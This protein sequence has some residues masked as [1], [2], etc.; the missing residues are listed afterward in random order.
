GVVEDIKKLG[1]RSLGVE[2]DVS[3]EFEINSAVSYI[4]NELGDI[5]ILVAN[6]GGGSGSLDENSASEIDSQHLK[7][8]VERNLYGTI[9][10][11]KAVS[12]SM[13]KNKY[14]KIITVT[15]VAGLRANDGGTYAHYGVAKAGI[16][17]LTKS[18]AQEL[19]PYN[20]TVNS[21]AP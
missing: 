11:V 14:G 7:N 2:A 5:D 15:S 12:D 20:I 4:R 18:L 6:A 21:I 17:N 3:K 9:Y 19:G 10:S 1:V 16:V 13:K 8:V